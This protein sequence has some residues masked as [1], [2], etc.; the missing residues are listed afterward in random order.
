MLIFIAL[1]VSEFLKQIMTHLYG[2]YYS[3]VMPSILVT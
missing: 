2:N 1:V 3:W